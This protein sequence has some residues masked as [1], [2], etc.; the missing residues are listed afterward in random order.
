VSHFADEPPE[1]TLL[2]KAGPLYRNRSSGCAVF[3]PLP[4]ANQSTQEPVEKG[5]NALSTPIPQPKKL[6]KTV[7]RSMSDG[8]K[9]PPLACAKRRGRNREEAERTLES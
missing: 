7:G 2:G 8:Q 5:L 1:Q 9:T 6:P 4:R 3:F